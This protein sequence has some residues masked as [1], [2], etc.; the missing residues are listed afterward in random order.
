MVVE[1][2]LKPSKLWFE[3]EETKENLEIS[4]IESALIEACRVWTWSIPEIAFHKE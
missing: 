3:G 2:T 1:S 4:L